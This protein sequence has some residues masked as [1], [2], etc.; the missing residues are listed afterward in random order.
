MSEVSLEEFSCCN[1]A[2][3]IIDVYT[4]WHATIEKWYKFVHFKGT[5]AT[6]EKLYTN[7]AKDKATYLG[8]R[9]KLSI[10]LI[11][12][13]M[14]KYKINLPKTSLTHMTRTKLNPKSCQSWGKTFNS[15]SMLLL[16]I[17]HIKIWEK[18]I[19]QGKVIIN[20]NIIELGHMSMNDITKKKS[21]ETSPANINMG[22]INIPG[23]SNYW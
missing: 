7:G 1:E 2:D 23:K 16:G 18:Y 17:R 12:S 15:Q 5:Q 4:S 6:N 11:K 8:S 14:Q 21:T 13:R 20:K 19:N 22:K 9:Q 10:M 3:M